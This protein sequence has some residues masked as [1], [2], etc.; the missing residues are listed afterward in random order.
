MY[1]SRRVAWI[2]LMLL[3]LS[4]ALLSHRAPAIWRRF[5]YESAR[6]PVSELNGKAVASFFP[7]GS[8]VITQSANSLVRI[9]DSS[10]ALISTSFSP[11]GSRIITQSP[12]GTARIWNLN[13]QLISQSVLLGRRKRYA[14][15]PGPDYIDIMENVP[16]AP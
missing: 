7:N 1:R 15:L 9:W 13:G 10:G 16:A 6:T 4:M 5:A 14:W 2:L 11:N 12:N 3:A 8:R